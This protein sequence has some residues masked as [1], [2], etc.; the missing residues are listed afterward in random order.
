MEDSYTDCDATALAELIRAGQASAEELMEEAIGRAERLNGAL[1][2]ISHPLYEQGRAAARGWRRDDAQAFGGVPFLLKDLGSPAAGEPMQMGSRPLREANFVADEDSYLAQRFRDAGLINFGRTNTPEFG[3]S[4]LTESGAHGL[5][6]N[7]WDLIRTP[8]GSSGGSAAAVA[9]RIVPAAHGNDGAGS[10]RMPAALTGIVGLKS[11]RARV[12]NG[13][14]LGEAWAG[15]AHEGVLT[16]TVRDAARML[17]VI[18]GGH[19]GDPY[20]AAPPA[21]PFAEAVGSDPGRLRIGVMTS[22]TEFDTHP[23][24]VVAVNRTADVLAGLGHD[25]TVAHP[26]AMDGWAELIPVLNR[27]V[28]SHVVLNHAVIE[29]LLQRKVDTSEFDPFTQHY[30]GIG[31]G[32]S[33]TDYLMSVEVLRRWSREMVSWWDDDG[34]D[35]LL[36]PTVSGPAPLHDERRFR[37]DDAEASARHHMAFFPYT[38]EFNVTG[39]PAISLPLHETEDGLPIGVQLVAASLREDQLVAVSSQLEQAMPWAD[40]RP[41]LT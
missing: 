33:T 19:A 13:P 6:S 32:L 38:P 28:S 15:F 23:E 35:L 10:I 41:T 26:A 37:P 9:A 21:R 16:R 25:I 27:V 39:Q 40:R 2:A 3:V 36:T 22:I 5:T 20:R 11:T 34:F 8:G 29:Q 12:S 31:A 30:L 4:M 18:S 7:P 1:G 24:C 14:A 17:D